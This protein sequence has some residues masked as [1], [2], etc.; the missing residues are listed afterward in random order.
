MRRGSRDAA[1]GYRLEFSPNLTAW[2]QALGTAL[3]LTP[4]SVQ[5]LG[6]GYEEVRYTLPPTSAD[7]LFLR[8]GVITP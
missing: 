7:P 5:D 1:L 4:S 3:P 6:N 8:L 2:S